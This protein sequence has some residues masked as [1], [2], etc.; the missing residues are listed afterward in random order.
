MNKVALVSLC[1]IFLA[2]GVGG[3]QAAEGPA[4]VVVKNRRQVLQVTGTAAYLRGDY[5][6]AARLL[7]PAAERGN[8]RAQTYLGF[9]Y[10]NGRGVPQ[11][12]IDAVYWYR[13]AAEQGNPS[14]QAQLGLMY[15]KGHGVPREF[16]VAHK[17][18]NLAAAGAN[19]RERE[20]YARL[21]N[22]VAFKMSPAQIA[23][24]QW[25]AHEWWARPERVVVVVEPRTTLSLRA[26]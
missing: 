26:K 24:A 10:A 23:E 15:D 16:V 17:W 4:A 7:L 25:L 20:Y 11:N 19:G 18:L 13:R 1:A 9:M 14:A 5:V 22:A 6:T 2:A 3:A 8:S 21:R 12:Y